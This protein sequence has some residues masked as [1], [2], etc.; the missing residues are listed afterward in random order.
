MRPWSARKA[1]RRPSRD[2]HFDV[3]DQESD[4]EQLAKAPSIAV[5]LSEKSIGIISATSI[6]PEGKWVGPGAREGGEDSGVGIWGI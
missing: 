6:A 3:R 4:G 5:V 1:P 2:R